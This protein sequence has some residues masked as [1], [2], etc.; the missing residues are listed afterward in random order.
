MIAIAVLCLIR[1]L[2]PFELIGA[3]VIPS[4][5]IWPFIRNALRFSLF[6]GISV[7]HLLLILWGVGSAVS[8]VFLMIKH[9]RFG[10]WLSRQ[11]IYSN[12]PLMQAIETILP[13]Q[14]EYSVYRTNR[15]FSPM[16]VGFL[17]PVFL[18]P[19]YDIPPKYTT[20]ILKHEYRHYQNKDVIA[21]LIF[22]L[23]CCFLWWNPLTYMII[24]NLDHCLEMNCDRFVV[25]EMTN[26][27]RTDYYEM[28]LKVYRS[29]EKNGKKHVTPFSAGF[30]SAG[31]EK[32]LCQRFELG[33][34]HPSP[35]YNR[36]IKSAILAVAVCSLILS[37]LFIIQPYNLPK[38]ASEMCTITAENAYLVPN[39]DDTYDLFI[40]GVFCQSLDDPSV[41]ESEPF[42]L[43]PIHKGEL[44]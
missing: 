16:V 20:P 27:E 40:D 3:K 7:F 19:E 26:A 22:R 29:G 11:P 31:S 15:V 37:Y 24:A 30:V 4:T 8:L 32:Q 9:I 41:L 2:L 34:Q 39:S 43:L 17:K 42:S 38:E 36:I 21:K 33:L 12:A 1:G 35:K 44:K 13:K 23:L 18:F 5:T 25:L 6:E 10:R 28:I 14:Q